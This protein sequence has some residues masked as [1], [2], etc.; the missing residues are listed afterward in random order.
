MLVTEGSASMLGGGEGSFFT[1]GSGG[2]KVNLIF[3]PAEDGEEVA[4]LV[5]EEGYVG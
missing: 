4:D 3:G 5:V 2:F 1:D